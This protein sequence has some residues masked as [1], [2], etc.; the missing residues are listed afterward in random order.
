MKRIGVVGVADGWSSERLADAVARRTGFR[1]LID[2]RDLGVDLATGAARAGQVEVHHLDALLLK[3][4]GIHYSPTDVDRLECLRFLHD[5]GLPMFSKPANVLRMLNRLNNTVALRLGGI[6]M[7]PTVITE[8]V[9]EAVATVAQFERAV[10]KPLF[11]TKARGMRVIKNTETTRAEV[12]SFIAEGNPLCYIQQMIDLPSRDLGVV[13]LGGQYLATY[14]RVGS[15]QSWST[16][17]STGG[18]YQAHQPSDAI[19]ELAHRAQALFELD[20]TCV[21]VAE[22]SAG[23]MVFEVSAFGGFRGLLEA[24]GIDAADLYVDYVLEKLR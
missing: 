5:R 3:K 8:N 17:T 16:S 12:E 15:G 14:A 23:P 6:P 7:P 4:V 9:L 1:C 13:F 22:T 24:N 20:F 19:L 11:S 21:D 18:R 2:L 10:F